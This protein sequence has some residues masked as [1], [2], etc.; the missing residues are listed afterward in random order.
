M[1]TKNPKKLRE[2]DEPLIYGMGFKE[3]KAQEQE[4]ILKIIEELEDLGYNTI[5]RVSL[6]LAIKGDEE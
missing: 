3:G 4:R 2:E 1:K 6:K 5:H